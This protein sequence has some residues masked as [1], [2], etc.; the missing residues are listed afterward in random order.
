MLKKVLKVLLKPF[1][2][3][4]AA[5]SHDNTVGPV[6]PP[7]AAVQITY[8]A[9]GSSIS[10]RTGNGAHSVSITMMLCHILTTF[11]IPVPVEIVNG[12]AAGV[13]GSRGLAAPSRVAQA[14]TTASLTA[15]GVSGAVKSSNTPTGTSTAAGWP[16]NSG[17]GPATGAVLG[18][19]IPL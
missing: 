14:D 8:S 16:K 11:L 12:A 6:P 5:V 3:V 2:S 17:S 4:S 18:Q 7:S 13:P 10:I 1:H 19:S 9:D 15:T